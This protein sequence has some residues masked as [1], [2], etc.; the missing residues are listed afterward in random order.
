MSAGRSRRRSP[1]RDRRRNRLAVAAAGAILLGAVVVALLSGGGSTPAPLPL[2]GTGRTAR[3][4]DPF[5]YEASRQGQFEAR[6]SA[7]SAQ[8][9]FTKSP[10]GA[11]AT[12]A[13][14]ASYRTA[15][16]AA[17]GGTGIDPSMLEAIV[18]L[19]SA[20]RPDAIAGSDPSAAA[21]LTQILAQTG[22]A[23]LGMH[24]DLPASRKLTAAIDRASAA[25]DGGLVTRLQSRRAKID[26]RFDPA[27]ALAA[28]VRYLKLARRRFGRAD[29]AIV[30]YHMGIGN[31][32]QV[33]GDYDGGRAV[34][35]AQLY[36]DISPS[37]NGTAYR[38]LSG[39]GDDSSLYYWRV[40]GAA[41]IMRL[42]RS[43]PTG[44][45]RLA[46]LQ[47]ADDYGA[48]VLHPPGAGQSLRDPNALAGA[49]ASRT[50][51]P[52]PSNPRRLGL[53]YDPGMG[54]L[55][56]RLG[57]REALYRG[58][59]APALDLLIELAARGQAVSGV[60]APLIV[61]STVTDQRYQGLLGFPD[62]P[63]T[64][65]FTFQLARR[66]ASPAQALALQSLLDR[67]QALNLIAWLR[68]PQSIEVTV[69]SDASSVLVHGV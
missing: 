18:F 67:L 61:T 12:A 2:P 66:Y 7:G 21:G 10:G 5:A 3:P 23:L 50:I 63:A 1:A 56:P 34:P 68:G 39:F 35:Y 69:A 54:S 65:G 6:A 45:Q 24:I 41:Q 42:Y 27:K 11:P 9:L 8:V 44:L 58:L 51:L 29:L 28:T 53:A 52:L 14:V 26:D 13:R 37:H 47:T 46:A 60:S 31:L 64:T 38:L 17:A 43:D 33:L 4:G 55:A 19:E 59:R 49:Y 22:Q 48:A 25:G 40:L 32:Q 20:G 36:F 62:P 15:V 16:N 57:A 30:S